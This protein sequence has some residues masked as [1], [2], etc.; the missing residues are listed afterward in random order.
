MGC[1]TRCRIGG[2]D[3]IDMKAER[4]HL[5]TTFLELFKSEVRIERDL[6]YVPEGDERHRLDVYTPPDARDAPVILFFYGGGWRSGDKKLFEHLGRAFAMR[7]IVAVVVNYRLTPTVKSPAHAEDCAAA[8][9]W[10][11]QNIEHYG[12][13]RS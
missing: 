10:T 13:S 8:T 6:A 5:P 3:R 2:G 7:G 11:Y 1:R 12:G 9:A 4:A